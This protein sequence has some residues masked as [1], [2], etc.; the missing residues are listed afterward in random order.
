MPSRPL[1]YYKELIHLQYLLGFKLE[2][3]AQAPDENHIS[4]QLCCTGYSQQNTL[5]ADESVLA[6]CLGPKC[7]GTSCDQGPSCIHVLHIP[8]KPGAVSAPLDQGQG[9]YSWSCT[10]ILLFHLHQYNPSLSPA[11]VS[12]SQ[13]QQ[14]SSWPLAPVSA[15]KAGSQKPGLLLA[16]TAGQKRTVLAGWYSSGYPLS[17]TICFQTVSP[18]GECTNICLQLTTQFPAQLHKRVCFKQAL[19]SMRKLFHL[20]VVI[21][22]WI[23]YS[24]VCYCE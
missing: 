1:K 10:S 2:P 6:S 4:G 9:W 7:R 21:T 13:R 22:L 3:P 24:T 12:P 18:K 20:G 23:Y 11:G 5:S 8:A 16:S 19:T 15:A 14:G 17:Q